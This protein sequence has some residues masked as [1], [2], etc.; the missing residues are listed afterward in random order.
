MSEQLT[1]PFCWFGGKR[2]AA[3]M[4]WG[5]FGDV[6]NYCEPFAGSLAVLL[7]R[8]TE[9]GI[10]TCND[11]DCYLANF[12]RAVRAAPDEVA[13]WADYPVSELDQNARHLWL[14]S[15]A[16]LREKMNTDADWFDAKAA[17]WWVYGQ[18]TWIGAGWC[19][20][21]F[22]R[23]GHNAGNGIHRQLPHLGDAG[24]GVNS[25]NAAIYE[26]MEKLAERLRR[27]RI[28]CGDWFRVLRPCVTIKHGLTA[29]FLDPP[30]AT[31]N[32]VAYSA[33]ENSET[34]A[35]EVRAWALENGGNPLFRIAL[36]G[37]QGEHEMPGWICDS[38]KGRKGYQ[39]TKT[40]RTHLERIWF[41][42]HCL[43]AERQADMFA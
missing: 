43:A 8:P 41:S 4:V 5:R 30:Y 33:G 24:K 21:A 20:S 18:N 32:D 2:R 10:E 27:V 6:P 28:C 26:W 23:D 17:G 42:P 11:L 14:V 22:Y 16:D 40:D 38:W 34:I 3:A 12:W 35:H 7:G 31:E 9:P 1:A 19:D 39:N 36:C 13:K 15:R 37:Y 25:P 29:V